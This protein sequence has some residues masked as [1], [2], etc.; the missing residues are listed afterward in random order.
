MSSVLCDNKAEKWNEGY[1]AC[2][3]LDVRPAGLN[4]AETRPLDNN[5]TAL[6]K[7]DSAE[8]KISMGMTG[9]TR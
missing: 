7:M 4:G 9:V 8:M 6:K 2:I 1:P 3:T 5:D